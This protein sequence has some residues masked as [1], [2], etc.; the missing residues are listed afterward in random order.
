MKKYIINTNDSG[1]RADKFILKVAKCLPKSLLYKFLRLKKIKLNRKR[2]QGNEILSEGDILELY[3]NDEFFGEEEKEKKDAEFLH[4]KG[5][6]NAIY[7]DENLAIIF[8]EPGVICHSG[9]EKG[10]DTL[11]D[12]LKK[13]LYDKG[14]FNPKSESS[15]SPSL[16]NRLDRNTSGL[17]IGAKSS[18]ALREINRKIAED[19]IKKSYRLVVYGKMEKEADT[20]TLFI[21]K[22]E[23]SQ[24]VLVSKSKKD[25]YKEAITKYKLISYDEETDTSYL[26]VQLITGRTHQIRASFDFIGHCLVGE[27]R[28]ISSKPKRIRL[29]NEPRYQMLCAFR[30]EFLK[31][32]KAGGLSYL[33]GKSFTLPKN[34]IGF[35][36]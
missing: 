20:I 28:Y 4:S 10:A 16:C 5:K 33:E 34:L 32:E 8:K 31:D 19:K 1:Q 36:E 12:M 18:M 35:G 29:K 26:E 21:K 2:C 15:F 17:V 24:S 3:I 25:G 14:E 22:P 6:L 11:V 13:Y 23:N 30:L 27:R 9:N 7:E